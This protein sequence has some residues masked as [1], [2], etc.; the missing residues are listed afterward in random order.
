[1][2]AVGVSLTTLH[3]VQFLGL[4][5]CHTYWHVH[6]KPPI[7]RYPLTSLGTGQCVRLFTRIMPFE[8]FELCFG[9]VT[10]A[11]RPQGSRCPKILFLIPDMGLHRLEDGRPTVPR[12]PPVPSGILSSLESPC[13]LL[14]NGPPFGTVPCIRIGPRLA[15]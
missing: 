2:R 6:Q 5:V 15:S 14:L 11:S 9:S 8:P 4:L 1:M 7:K 3:T 10:T 13:G 12:M